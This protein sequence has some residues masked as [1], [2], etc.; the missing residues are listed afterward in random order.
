MAASCCYVV[1]RPPF[2]LFRIAPGAIDSGQPI[3]KDP[4]KFDAT[5]ISVSPDGRTLAFEMHTEKTGRD[6]Y[7]RPLDGSAPFQAVRATRSEERGPSLS[8]DGTWIVYQSD[9]LGHPEVYAQPFPG[10]GDR[11]QLSERGGTDP[12][13][14]KNGE[15]FFLHG[16][17]LRVVPARPAGRTTFEASRVL[18]SY[19][20]MSAT[21]SES[22]TFDVTRDGGR[23]IA[24]TIPEASRPRQ[25]EIV[26][27]WTGELERLVPRTRARSGS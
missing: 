9:E 22:Q 19:P 26:T 16:H 6:I 13:W 5:A 2:E 24:I 14:A 21:I 11:L 1:D 4:A 17:E 18:F 27:D 8:P 3:W 25:I 20:I 23:V 10:P 12:L 15:I 7:A